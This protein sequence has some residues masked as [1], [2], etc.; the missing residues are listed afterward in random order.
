MVLEGERGDV[1][2]ELVDRRGEREGGA[3]AEERHELRVSRR[4]R[5]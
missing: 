4:V 2:A 1:A 3:K 5:N